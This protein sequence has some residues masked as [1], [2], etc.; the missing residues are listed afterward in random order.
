MVCFYKDNNNYANVKFAGLYNNKNDA[1]ERITNLFNGD[2]YEHINNT[3]INNNGR[4]I[5]WVN[6]VN[7]GDNNNFNLNINQPFNSISL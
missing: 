3:V 1:I 6:E 7:I 5:A 2:I 4:I